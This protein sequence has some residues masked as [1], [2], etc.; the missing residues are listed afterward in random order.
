MGLKEI[1]R[2]ADALGIPNAN[3]LRVNVL[4][5]SIQHEEGLMPCFSEAW[6]T[7]CRVDECPFSAACSSNMNIAASGEH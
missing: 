4:V 1:Q 2:L 5:H 7:P 3:Q 6:S